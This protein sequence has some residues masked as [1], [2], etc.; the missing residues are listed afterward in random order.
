MK[1][2]SLLDDRTVICHLGTTRHALKLDQIIVGIH[3][4]ILVIQMHG[5]QVF[6]RELASLLALLALEVDGEERTHVGHGLWVL[7]KTSPTGCT[8]RY[9]ELTSFDGALFA[10]LALVVVDREF[11][12]RNQEKVDRAHGA[13]TRAVLTVTV[14]IQDHWGIRNSELDL[15]A[16]A[17]TCFGNGSRFIVSH[18]SFL[19]LTFCEGSA[20]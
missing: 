20:K 5:R 10:I 8:A 16:A 3:E 19:M 4:P 12:L 18:F 13:E 6:F 11:I 14:A 7:I 15:S 9:N 17:G 2:P 1:I